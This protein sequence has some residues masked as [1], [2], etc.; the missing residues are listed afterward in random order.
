MVK[1]FRLGAKVVEFA[2]HIPGY[3]ISDVLSK[4]AE[5]QISEER[6]AT[7]LREQAFRLRTDLEAFLLS[8]LQVSLMAGDRDNDP[9]EVLLT[10]K[11]QE[12][13]L[14]TLE[15]LRAIELEPTK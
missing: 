9:L 6:Q 4:M 2:D 13:L 3:L 10:D 8:V 15:A 11:Q 1:Q 5:D 12:S 7:D 14:E